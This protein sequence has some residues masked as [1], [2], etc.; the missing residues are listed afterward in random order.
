MAKKKYTYIRIYKESAEALKKRLEKMNTQDLRKIGVRNGNIP[1]IEF[2][3]FLFKN[4]IFISDYELKQMAKRKF[5]G[6]IC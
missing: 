1:Q 5:R 2:T 3:S 4:P 6:K